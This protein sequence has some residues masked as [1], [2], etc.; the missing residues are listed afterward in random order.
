MGQKVNPIGLR[1]GINKDWDANWFA[2]KKD[3]AR[4]INNDNKIRKFLDSQRR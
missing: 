3:V 4:F 1:V 2:E